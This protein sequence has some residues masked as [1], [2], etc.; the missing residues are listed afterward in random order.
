MNSNT[1]TIVIVAVAVLAIIYLITVFRKSAAKKA[2][3]AAPAPLAKEPDSLRATLAPIVQ[4]IETKQVS[5]F[6]K[7]W[8]DKFANN[9]LTVQDVELLNSRIAEGSTDQ[10]N[11]ILAL[12]PNARQMFEHINEQLKLN[13]APVA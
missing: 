10:V 1:L 9:T 13:A 7:H 11:G 4:E 5:S 8:Y 12:H 6:I 3:A 2:A